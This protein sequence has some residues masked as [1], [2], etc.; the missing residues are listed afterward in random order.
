[1]VS[2]LV[3]VFRRHATRVCPLCDSKVEL[4]RRRCQVCGYLFDESRW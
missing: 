3:H 1:M 2:V 4:G